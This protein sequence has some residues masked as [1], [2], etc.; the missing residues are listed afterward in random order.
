[1]ELAVFEDVLLGVH[2]HGLGAAHAGVKV[3]PELDPDGLLEDVG[4]A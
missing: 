3:V 4:D 2:V 1:M